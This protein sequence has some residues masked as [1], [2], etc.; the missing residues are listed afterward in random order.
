MIVELNN[1]VLNVEGDADYL[2]TV[3]YFIYNNTLYKGSELEFFVSELIVKN[4]LEKAVPDFSGCF[5]IVCV[6]Y[7]LKKITVIQ[8]RW[9]TYPL[10]YRCKEAQMLISDSYLLL[11]DKYSYYRTESLAELLGFGHVIGNKTL[12]SNI[13]EFKPHCITT[14]KP[15]NEGMISIVENNYWHYQYEPEPYTFK[16]ASKDFADLW[17]SKMKII[18]SAFKDEIAYVPLSAGLD[19]RLIAAGLDQ[20]GIEQYNL[21][22]GSGAENIEISTAKQVSNCLKGS[23]GHSIFNINQAG[24]RQL[25]NQ[26]DHAYRITTGYFGEK[27]L[28][29][30]SQ[31]KENIS[32]FM[33]GHSGD[34]MAGSHLKTKMKLWKSKEDIAQ[35]LIIFKSSPLCR[36]LYNT[37]K[38]FKDVIW[39]SVMN[40]LKDGDFVNS[41]I[42]WDLEERQ[43]RY[44]IRSVVAEN[45]T[46]LPLLVLPY[47]DYDLMDFFAKMPFRY[48]H[49]TRLYRDAIDR[50]ILKK[51]EAIRKIKVNGQALNPFLKGAAREYYLKAKAVIKDEKKKF[52]VFDHSIDWNEFLDFTDLPEEVPTEWIDKGFYKSNAR[53]YYALKAFHKDFISQSKHL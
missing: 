28:W 14:I 53:F 45:H 36:H 46:E 24:Y 42:Q 40:S 4:E 52:M 3:G 1:S 13:Y 15:D 50:Y 41:F 11:N 34:F 5:Q 18:S 17:Q 12:L 7:K 25:I 23:L 31:N 44:I 37:N 49:N 35:Y 26:A 33:P 10:F 32:C 47:F 9:G 21:T 29:Y 6:N 27:D 20:N 22:F 38:A 19:S 48:L 51:Q 8:D 39:Q 2:Y 16:T 43:R 30:P